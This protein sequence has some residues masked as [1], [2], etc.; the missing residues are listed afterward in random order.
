MG[1]TVKLRRSAVPGKVPI[2][3]Q[4][5]LGELSVNTADGKLFFAK[6]GS[7]GPSIEEVI[8]TNTQNTGSIDLVGALTASVVSSSFKGDGS[9]LYNIPSSGV[10]GL[11]LD[12][13]TLGGGIASIT[14]TQFDV[15]VNSVING[16]LTATEI[17]GSGLG[18]TNVPVNISGSSHTLTNYDGLFTK[19]HFDDS[20]GIKVEGDSTTGIAKI[21]LDGV[22][23][24]GGQGRTKLLEVTTLSSTWTFNHGLGEKYPAIMVFD[25]N[26]NVIIP[27]N[28]EAVNTT[29]LVV[30]FASPQIGYVT[31]TVGG[32]LP[33]TTSSEN[34]TLVTVSGVPTWKD[35]IL[36]GSVPFNTFS[37][38]IDTIIG[39]LETESAS[40]RSDFNTYTQTLNSYTSSNNN[41]VVDLVSNTGSYQSK[42]EFQS[43]T[44]SITSTNN[45][46]NSRIGSLESFTGSIDNTYATDADV[47]TLR[48]D[49]NT[50][51]SSN[52][53]KINSLEVISSSH[54]GRLDSIES[55]TGSYLINTD[56]S[57]LEGQVSSL[58]TETGSINT[59]LSSIEST[60]SSFDGRL[61][62]LE[63]ESGSVD[64]RL[65][66]IEITTA[67]LDGR[68]GSIETTT[69]S[70]EGKVSSLETE[71]GSIRTTVN[72]YTSSNDGRVSNLESFQTTVED[73][74]EF[75]G[76]NVTIKGNLLVKGTETRVNSTTIE[77]SDN[78]ISLNGSG[79]ANGGIEVRDV[80]SPNVLSGSLI[81]D[82]LENKWKGGPKGSEE[83]FILEGDYNTFTSSIDSTLRV[84]LNSYT[85]SA[86]GR[87]TNVENSISLLDNTYATDADVTTLRGDL[88]TYTSSNDTTNSN[89]NG[90]L[91][92]IESVSGSY[93]TSYNDE[94]TTGATFNGVNGVVTFTRNDGDTFNVDLDGRYLTSY[95][96][97]DP[98]FSASPSVGITGQNIVNWDASYGWGNHASVGYI[99]GFTNTN[100]FTTG[101]TFNSSDGIITFT[102][103]NGGDTFTVDIDGKYS[104]LNHTH[105]FASLTSKPTTLVGYGITDA[106]SSSNVSNWDTAYSWGNHASTYSLLNHT[107]TFASLT[108][109][110][111]TLAGYGITDASSGGHTHTFASLTSK[112][113]TLSGYGITDAASSSNVSNWDTA[114]GWG[115]HASGGYLT[116]VTNVSGY[117][118]YLNAE[119]NRTISPSEVS[120]SRM[121]FGFTSWANNNQPPYADFLH[122]RSYHD[123]SGGEDNLV[124]FK[125]S[126]IGMR[127]WQQNFGSTTAYSTYEDV[128]TTGDFTTSDTGNWNTAYGWGDHSGLYSLLNHTHTFAS[129]TSKPTTLSGYGITDAA[130]GSHT[131]TFASLTSK[132]TTLS[133]YGITDSATSTQGTKA[134]TA[135]GWGNHASGGYLTSYSEIDTLA[136]VTARGATTSTAVTLSSTNNHFNGH[137]YFD[138]YDAAGN[139]YPHYLP[140]SNGTGAIVNMRVYSTASTLR[141][142]QLNG[143]NGVMT[144]NGSIAATGGDSTNWN[145]SYG[146]GNHAN[147]N[148]LTSSSALNASNITSGTYGDYFS[149]STRYN[150]GLIDGNS[151]Q[152]RDKIRVWTSG[153]FSI[154]MKDNYT[155][156][157]LNNNYAMSFQMSS[158]VGRGFWWGND[159]HAD[160][161]GVMAL[162]TTGQLN[163]AKSISIGEGESV[164]TP[165]STPLYV[166]GVT[167]GSTVFEVQGTQGQLFS[168][169]D[170]LTGDLFSVSDISGIPI[171][172]VNA[173]GI[174]T[175]DDTL[176]V[177]GDVFAYHSSDERLKDNIK[178]IENAIDKIKMIGGYEFDWNGLS[179]NQGHD[180]GVIAQEVEK[181]L[182]EVVATRSNGYKAVRYEKLTALLIQAN[183]ELIE[184][185]E[186]LEKKLNNK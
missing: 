184:R 107:H 22:A 49:L 16:S 24:D 167:S 70:L 170:D 104:L 86:D 129:L 52:D 140:G 32:G 158:D 121:R 155:F 2:N 61:N 134:D 9:E 103:N 7:F 64:G 89:Q 65:D 164:T 136:T 3:S 14:S 159:G 51:S 39:S 12:R 168:I 179:K 145:T 11:S 110:P 157:G 87:I 26:D 181:V 143:T 109:K 54:D 25:S 94:Y 146:W 185:V 163:V 154:G 90:R 106:A 166:E 59:K 68:L 30:S 98:I 152:T 108:S 142:F 115:N 76:S 81:W 171:L 67:S 57:T 135:Y 47:T 77:V 169:T 48:G 95:T 42:G 101:A 139:H 50:Y 60:T 150:I 38:S 4:L 91:D 122:L 83:D 180:V 37:S 173:S 114:Y 123:S 46:Q 105:T 80:T 20:T 78:I 56:L 130:S 126:G 44:S 128:W 112:P 176:H 62:S 127:I 13:I 69:A 144:W 8:T 100:E 141:V 175:I 19:F 55:Q 138:A 118:N 73:G 53:G 72:T 96:E 116:S 35:G 85:S 183:K 161:Q 66:S 119:D 132:P 124:M 177:K 120:S 131:H 84:D 36:S 34:K 43:Y 74:L 125:K 113:T 178:P 75:T 156:G 93:L 172:T 63:V 21:Y 88:N 40:I 92:S 160:S 29:Q 15:N 33:E 10:T 58:E 151:D 99:T 6:S 182:P 31:A 153:T 97:T 137:H 27:Q 1:Q 149:P 28:I 45:T 18:L 23:S 79:A 71:S 117:S 17:T 186:E 162:T 133:G 147:S 148:Y 5:Q 41:I 102:R 174:V 111:T 165:S 82:G